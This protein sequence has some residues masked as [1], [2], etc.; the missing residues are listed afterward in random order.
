[1]RHGGQSANTSGGGKNF[2]SF[3]R[4]S[5]TP[6]PSRCQA[7]TAE[8]RALRNYVLKIFLLTVLAIPLLAM[9]LFFLEVFFLFWVFLPSLFVVFILIRSIYT[10]DT[11]LDTIRDL[12][13]FIPI[14]YSEGEWLPER[15][16]R[17]THVLILINVA[18]HYAL[19]V[20]GPSVREAVVENLSFV[21]ERLHLWNVPLSLLASMFLHGDA[22]HLW[23]NMFFLWVFGLV[24]ERHIG[25]RQFTFFY[26]LT[27]VFSDILSTAIHILFLQELP[28][29]IG[30]S[31][32]ISGIMGVFAVRL[33]FRRLIFPIPILGI[34]SLIL[35]LNLKIRVNSLFIIGLYFI[36]DLWGGIQTLLG[37]TGHIAYWAHIGGLVAGIIFALRLKFQ[38]TA[39]QEM[40][41]QKALGAIDSEFDTAEGEKL[42]RRV[43]ELNPESEEALLFLARQK[44]ELAR[45]E[46]GRA[47]YLKLIRLLFETKPE[48]AAEVFAEYFPIYHIPLDPASQYRLTD[49]LQRAGWS[50]IAARAL[51]AL[52]DDPATPRPW[53]ERILFR[54]ARMLEELH[55]PEA[56]RFRYEQLLE[57]Y[58]D[59]QKKSLVLYRLEKL[60]AE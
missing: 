12:L 16:L 24:L 42:L 37:S 22:G 52:A 56:A 43:L 19:I 4:A 15:K 8:R 11:V 28:S 50:D 48:R 60:K 51:E 2:S 7:I 35:P 41:I 25:W 40:Y 38:D 17:A 34:F 26:L 59:F 30:A 23:W 57:R 58:P 53:G 55:L 10:G 6:L 14:R 49:V 54:L 36:G 45:T 31:G 1:M 29:G 18:I 47:L 9:V 32:A 13:T 5:S 46:E 3:H 44:S 27:G 21:P 39:I 20:F 33:Y